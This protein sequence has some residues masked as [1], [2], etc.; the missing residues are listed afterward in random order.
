LIHNDK[1]ADILKLKTTGAHRDTVLKK[2]LDP[3]KMVETDPQFVKYVAKFSG[4]NV[5]PGSFFGGGGGGGDGG[6]ARGG[7]IVG[8]GGDGG[9]RGVGTPPR[10]V[11][12]PPAHNDVAP[13]FEAILAQQ[14]S[15]GSAL[16]NV[17]S[18]NADK[19]VW[20]KTA[21]KRSSLFALAN[22]GGAAA[23]GGEAAAGGE[24]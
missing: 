16:E 20:A 4:G 15:V 3:H 8:G 11:H 17:A 13:A 23:G 22:E 1:F 6:G 18:V 19:V 9:A 21:R 10:R 14:A 2:L 5:V 12:N 24:V 7:G